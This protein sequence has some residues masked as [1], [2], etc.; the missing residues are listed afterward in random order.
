MSKSHPWTLLDV[1]DTVADAVTLAVF[2]LIAWM[3]AVSM[4]IDA[5]GRVAGDD[6][7][8]MDDDSACGAAD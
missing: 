8:F 1:M 2:L 5:A 7:A 3:M 6:D 4:Q